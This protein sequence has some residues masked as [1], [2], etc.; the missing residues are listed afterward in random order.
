[1]TT[2]PSDLYGGGRIFFYIPPEGR[3][4][5][6]V[7]I[8]D[9]GPLAVARVY[10]HN[11]RKVVDGL[12]WIYHKLHSCTIGPYFPDIVLADRA[13]KKILKHYSKMFFEQPIAWL[14]RQIAFKTW[15]DKNI[16]EPGDLFGGQWVDEHGKPVPKGT[17]GVPK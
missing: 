7:I 17:T 1:M 9:G 8:S 13:M 12:F 10:N 11:T 3:P 6:L 2:K 15:V 14:A 16:G 4:V 5:E